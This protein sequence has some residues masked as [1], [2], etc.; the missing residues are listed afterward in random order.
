MSASGGPVDT[1]VG[2]VL[3]HYRI[4]EQI[5]RGGM[6]VVYRAHD[7]VLRR[8][9]AVKVL[10]SSFATDPDRLRRFEQEARSAGA[11]NHPNILAIYDFGEHEGSP[12][13]VSELLEGK[14]LREQ[15][16]GRAMPVWKAVDYGIQ[17]ARGLSA[18]YEKRIVHR[19]VKPE[20][21]F[22]TNDGRVKILDFGIAKLL[23]PEEVRVEEGKTATQ[24]PTEA[25]VL[26]GTTGYMSPEQVRGAPVDHRSDL[27]SLGAVL[28]EMLSGRRAFEGATPADSMSAILSYDPPSLSSLREDIPPDLDRTIRRCLEKSTRERFQTAWDLASDLERLAGTK[29][30]RKEAHSHRLPLPAAVGLGLAVLLGLAALSDVGGLRTRLLTGGHASPIRSLA[31]LPLVNF[32]HNPD[33]EYFADGMTEQLITTLAQ[34]GTLRVISRTSVMRFKGT[35]LSL[36][37]IGRKLGVYAIVEGSVQRSGDRVRITAQLIRAA[38]D[39]HLWAQTYERDLS[40]ALALQAEVA[41]AIA[42]EVQAKLTPRQQLEVASTR[43]VSRRGYE[44]YLRALDAYRRWDKRSEQAALEFLNQAIREDS[45][46]APAWATIGLVYLVEPGQFGTRDEDFAHARQALDRALALDPALGLA[47]AVKAEIEYKR[48]WNWVAAER[49]LKRAIELAPSLFEAHHSYSHLLMNMGRVEE[50]LEQSRS[51]LALDPLNTTATLH[52]GWHY[53]YARQFDRAIPEYEAT[54]RL[55]PSYA[56]AYAQLAWVYGLT[57]R[58]DEATAA[59]NKYRELTGSPN[60]LPMGAA[61]AARRGRTDE[62]LKMLS[63]LI[64]GANRGQGRAYDVATIFALLGR[65]NDAFHWLDRAFNKHE[66]SLLELKVD[67]FL[68][69]LRSDPRFAALI[70][71]IGIPA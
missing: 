71:R 59:L 52:M 27:F 32:S 30:P 8:D 23:V 4:L 34:I 28:Y 62:A 49:D 33:Q 26:L 65:K 37:E 53:L 58:F 36:P 66:E 64:D 48:D 55:D 20:N 14:T 40:D 41:G 25:G 24:S 45:T 15:M 70:R 5:G 56:A 11:L 3:S 19:D 9:V 69:G 44:L 54:L 22:V 31:V 42:R 16:G 47:H 57:R 1:L 50:S 67:P 60:A 43:T 12:Y 38:S 7:E 13:V 63:E 18:A 10:P 2:K 6:G 29:P 51:A 68:E 46:Y 39:E 61:L 35:A 17:I 21:I